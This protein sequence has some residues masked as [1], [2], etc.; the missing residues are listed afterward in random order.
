MLQAWGTLEKL[1]K[2]ILIMQNDDDW[3][4]NEATISLNEPWVSQVRAT[5]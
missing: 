1:R 2:R 5:L 4:N 3:W